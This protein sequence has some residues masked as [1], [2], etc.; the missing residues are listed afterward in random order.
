MHGWN[1]LPPIGNY[2]FDTA[3]PSP[4]RRLTI[5][6]LAQLWRRDQN[7]ADERPKT[8]ATDKETKLTLIVLKRQKP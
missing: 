6:S 2:L 3:G 4:T 8:F 5:R 7:E 1:K